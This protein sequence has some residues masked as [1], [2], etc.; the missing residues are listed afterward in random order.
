MVILSQLSIAELAGLERTYGTRIDLPAD[1]RA[2]LDA[3][4]ADRPEQLILPWGIR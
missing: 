1:V 2:R 3:Y 4:Y